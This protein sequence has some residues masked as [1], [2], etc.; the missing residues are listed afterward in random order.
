M[1][2]FSRR[3]LVFMLACAC[4]ASGAGAQG[5]TPA[6]LTFAVIATRSADQM[7]EAWRPFVE[8]LGTH[9]HQPVDLRVY[10]EAKELVAA[11]K[12]GEID[13]AWMGNAPALDVV[14]SGVG[15]VFAQMVSKEGNLGYNS[16]LIVPKGS[17]LGSLSDVLQN[18]KTLR[19]GDGDPKSTSGHLVP[20]YYAFQKNGINDVNAI[21]KSTLS[22]NHQKNLSMVARGE[23]DVATANTEELRFFTRDFPDLAKGVRVIW[24][25]PLIPQSPLLWKNSLPADVRRKTL[26]FTVNFGGT[27]TEQRRILASLNDLS[28]FRQSSNRQLVPVADIE[29]FK[30]RQA[31]NN[32][33]TLSPEERAKQ[34]DEVIRRGSR[35]DLLLKLTAASGL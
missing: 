16:V 2:N 26:Q 11:F 8:R 9:L 15:A 22:S 18:A 13:F 1:P 27:N 29:T 5:G 24:Q 3:S 32:D 4:A 33:D 19:F 31:I 34:I 17:K 30:A 28:G 35:L 14:E 10:G 20:Y 21:F 23:V 6:S 7:K 12:K 25:S